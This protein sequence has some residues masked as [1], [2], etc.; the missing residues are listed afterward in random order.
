MR[1]IE[2]LG[3]QTVLGGAVEGR[4]HLGLLIA[5]L[6]PDPA[7]PAPL[8][9]DFAGIQIAT[10]SYQR[11]TVVTLHRLLRAR[12]SNFYLVIANAGASV[13]EEL[14]VLA[15]AGG[16][17]FLTCSLHDDGSISSITVIGRLD[18]KQQATFDEVRS[19]GETDAREL[20]AAQAGHEEVGQTAFN[21][22]LASLVHLGLIAELTRGKSK[23]YRPVLTET[24][25]GK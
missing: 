18:A 7:E 10:A 16:L 3:N 9:A 22:R 8:F 12:R 5:A 25:H 1:I 20:M 23:R 11:E 21:N 24:S 15:D 4:R 14:A 19:R 6:G 2:I 13:L 17:A